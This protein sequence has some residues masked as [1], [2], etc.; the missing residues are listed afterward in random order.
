MVVFFILTGNPATYLAILFYQPGKRIA[1]FSYLV[2]KC[3]G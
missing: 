1:Q 3:P 2:G